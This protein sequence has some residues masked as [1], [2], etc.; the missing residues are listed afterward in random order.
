MAAMVGEPG[1]SAAR[2]A[3][4]AHPATPTNAVR[5]IEAVVSRDGDRLRLTYL[6]AGG[7]ERLRIPPR[8]RVRPGRELWRHTCFEAFVGVAGA[9][10]YHELNLAPSAEW[11]VYAFTAY[12]DGGALDDIA[13]QPRIVVGADDRE[14]EVDALVDLAALSPAYAA[15]P[16]RVA[17]AAVVEETSGAL[18]YWAVRHPPG[19]PDFHH[20]DGFVVTLEPPGDA[21]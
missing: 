4:T 20:A 19:V 17:L 12:R 8:G 15:A 9:A 11:T 6:L 18:S 1:R 21:C 3:L 10:A 5:A 2:T 13:G 16:L 7:L 14:L